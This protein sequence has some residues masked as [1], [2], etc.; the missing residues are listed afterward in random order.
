MSRQ[1]GE[2]VRISYREQTL[3]SKSGYN[4]SGLSRLVVEEREEE[5]RDIPE[6]NDKESENL[7]F[8]KSS[9]GWKS[10]CKRNSDWKEEPRKKRRKKLQ[11][12]VMDENWGEGVI[13]DL[14]RMEGESTRKFLMDGSCNKRV[15][16]KTTQSLL[17][18]MTETEL[19]C[20]KV[21]LEIIQC[22]AVRG[23]HLS[24]LK[25]VL[26]TC[27]L[28]PTKKSTTTSTLEHEESNKEEVIQEAPVPVQTI[29]AK[30]KTV[31]EL[32]RAKELSVLIQE[33]RDLIKEERLSK[34]KRLEQRWQG[35]KEHHL[36]LRWAKEWLLNSV[37][38]KVVEEGAARV[39]IR[40]DGMMKDILED[41]VEDA[42]GKNASRRMERKA[43]LVEAEQQRNKLLMNLEKY[44]SALE[45]GIPDLEESFSEPD[46]CRK[47]KRGIEP[48]QI[49]QEVDMI[50]NMVL[51]MVDLQH[52]CGISTA[53]P[54]WYCCWLVECDRM[55]KEI[56][57]LSTRILNLKLEI[58][59]ED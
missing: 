25:E 24:S 1:V 4:R 6:E 18:P 55:D 17:K 40:V 50:I 32:F 2:A 23:K 28:K 31:R 29:P 22:T 47:R 42:E 59:E 52:N 7:T 39:Y 44:W 15:D 34:K 9:E 33:E 14:E 43:R 27:S 45:G 19:W 16:Q 51:G 20:R 11:F 38:D 54:A 57:E 13:D 37:A 48:R 36:R 3:N 21:V 30:Q 41:A 10:G 53:C 58:D 8:K 46:L 49:N 26:E 56:T 5:S 35:V 12:E